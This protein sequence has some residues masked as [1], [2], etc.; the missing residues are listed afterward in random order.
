MTPPADLILIRRMAAADLPAV[1][2]I[3]RISFSS[4][5]N[6]GAYWYELHENERARCW[7]AV[8]GGRVAAALVGWLVLDEYQIGTIA[9]HPDFRRRGIGRR[10]MAAAIEEARGAG[11]V[12]VTLEVRA[13]NRSAQS[14][15]EGFG[16]KIVGRR[17]R[18]YSDGEDAL[19]M[20]L[21]IETPE[22]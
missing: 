5:W 18:F 3:D 19:L 14:L 13:G 11:A 9:V 12:Q 21:D 15:Y 16:F 10:L 2:E 1:E 20:N 7:V 4:P 17:P 22:N 8:A 6:P